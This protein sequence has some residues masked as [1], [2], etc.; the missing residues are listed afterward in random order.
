MSVSH[1]ISPSGSKIDVQTRNLA[2]TGDM[3]VV[4]DLVAGDVIIGFLGVTDLIVNNTTSTKDLNVAEDVLVGENIVTKSLNVI[5]G[6]IEISNGQLICEDIVCT[7]SIQITTSD[8]DDG[9]ILIGSGFSQLWQP[10]LIGN[11]GGNIPIVT[12]DQ[13][14]GWWYKI[15]GLLTFSV[16]ITVTGYNS[17]GIQNLGIGNLPFTSRND[18]INTAC[19]VNITCNPI[20][21]GGSLI[22]RVG[23]SQTGIIY[24][25][26]TIC[27]FRKLDNAINADNQPIETQDGL[28]T[29]PEAPIYIRVSG[30][31]RL[32][33]V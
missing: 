23:Q 8:P 21:A 16:D 18:G 25:N 3:S 19:A 11:P 24:P 33:P 26:T 9:L 22:S 5:N 4:G 31:Y 2:V 27:E 10:T 14:F 28:H 20:N 12:Y 6:N 32:P 17:V 7:P 29:A 13:Q 15:G 1:I 30:S